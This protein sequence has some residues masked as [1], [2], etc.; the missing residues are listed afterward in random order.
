MWQAG[1]SQCVCVS[2][3]L[4]KSVAS[5]QE[6]EPIS[7]VVYPQQ[8][9]T[10]SSTESPATNSQ[11]DAERS[12]STLLHT[13][14]DGGDVDDQ[15]VSASSCGGTAGVRKS[16]RRRKNGGE[17]EGYG[18]EGDSSEWREKE[19]VVGA[20]HH[21]QQQLLRTRAAGGDVEISTKFVIC[22]RVWWVRMVWWYQGVVWAGAFFDRYAYRHTREP[23][24]HTHTHITY[25]FTPSHGLPACH[26][27]LCVCLGRSPSVVASPLV[28]ERAPR[29]AWRR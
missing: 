8:T 1:P 25:A 14:M 6:R 13:Q 18:S 5:S 9:H 21:L 17:M 16:G 2:V 10:D 11:G 20:D 4:Q 7:L 23:E 22:L 19:G 12:F 27:V 26:S 3:C 28:D 29:D 24:D 15:G